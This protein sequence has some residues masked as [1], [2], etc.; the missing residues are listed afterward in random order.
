V[1]ELSGG[2][3]GSCWDILG[4]RGELHLQPTL[5]VTS[6]SYKGGSGNK[7]F[8]N[9]RNLREVISID[10]ALKNLAKSPGRLASF[11]KPLQEAETRL[12]NR[13]GLFSQHPGAGV[14]LANLVVPHD[15]RKLHKT[16]LPAADDEDKSI[17]VPLGKETSKVASPY[18]GIPTKSVNP[19]TPF[20][21]GSQLEDTQLDTRELESSAT[22]TKTSPLV[23]PNS[24]RRRAASAPPVRE[25][26]LREI[27]GIWESAF[28][29]YTISAL[30]Y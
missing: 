26:S 19:Q 24:G 12:W 8:G 21:S 27:R 13:L 18:L 14:T 3:L 29:P 25:E 15:T 6:L 1:L 10:E 2:M 9:P 11:A 23:F 7:R 22:I 30:T 5:Y 16:A 4:T 28:Y 20:L 17:P